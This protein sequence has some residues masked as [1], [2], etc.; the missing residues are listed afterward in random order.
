MLG[1]VSQDRR[2]CFPDDPAAI[3]CH[4]VPGSQRE[5][6][7]FQ[8]EQ[9]IA[10]HVDR[11]LFIVSDAS[12]A[13]RRRRLGRLQVAGSIGRAE[14]LRSPGEAYSTRH[15]AS[16]SRDRLRYDAAPCDEEAYVVMGSPATVVS[17][18][19]TVRRI[20]EWKTVSPNAWTTRSSTSRQC[21]VRGSYMVPR[22]PRISSF[23]L[24]RSWT[25]AMVSVS[26]AIPR[27]AKN[28]H[29]RGMIT[30][31]AAVNALIVSRPSDG[32]QSIKITSYRSRIFSSTRS[33]VCSRATS[34]TSCTS[35]AERSMLLGRMSRFS[36]L[37]GLITSSTPTSRLS[38]R[39]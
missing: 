28:S 38:R 1:E 2:H 29:S 16:T 21:R 27:R 23:A 33:N 11:D 12:T 5:P 32:A 18:N 10:A 7:L 25:L 34:E 39:S 13:S 37:V 20:T 26:R 8:S 17:G 22:I 9:L 35:A 3:H 31:S 6:G 30:L 15:R 4:R 14:Q 19:F 24:S 36:M